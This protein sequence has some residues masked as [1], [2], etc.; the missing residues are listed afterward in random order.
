MNRRTDIVGTQHSPSWPRMHLSPRDRIHALKWLFIPGWIESCRRR[1]SHIPMKLLNDRLSSNPVFLKLWQWDRIMRKK[2]RGTHE[3]QIRSTSRISIW[4]KPSAHRIGFHSKVPN[5]RPRGGF[6]HCG[7]V[8]QRTIHSR[9]GLELGTATAAVIVS[10][11]RR[12]E[13]WARP[14]STSY[15]ESGISS[16]SREWFGCNLQ[17]VG[18]LRSVPKSYIPRFRDQIPPFGLHI[19]CLFGR[20]VD[21]LHRQLFEISHFTSSSANDLI[22]CNFDWEYG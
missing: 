5:S 20:M 14:I 10:D 4:I 7:R 18:V 12:H 3:K 21:S 15:S 19:S 6:F 22:S 2:S 16:L 17:K 13:R 1:S 11:R 9:L 8:F